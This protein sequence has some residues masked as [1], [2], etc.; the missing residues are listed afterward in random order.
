MTQQALNDI[1]QPDTHVRIIRDTLE[2]ERSMRNWVFR[3]QPEKLR[4]KVAEIDAALESLGALE[5]RF[6]EGKTS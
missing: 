3:N 5:R 2:N 4:K 1:L 6:I